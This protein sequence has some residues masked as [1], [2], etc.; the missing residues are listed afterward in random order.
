VF[1][2]QEC[3]CERSVW[4]RFIIYNIYNVYIRFNL[5]CIANRKWSRGKWS[6]VIQSQMD[7][8]LGSVLCTLLITI[9]PKSRFSYVAVPNSNFY[10]LI[11]YRIPVTLNVPQGNRLFFLYKRLRVG[12]SGNQEF[13]GLP[14][15][16]TFFLE[17][18]EL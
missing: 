12:Q 4:Y 14:V 16:K 6:N 5:M 11:R 17:F 18:C 3:L 8:L 13:H 2:Q 10:S 9:E 15:R 7:Y 1:F